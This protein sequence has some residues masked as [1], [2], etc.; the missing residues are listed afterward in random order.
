LEIL[1]GTLPWLELMILQHTVIKGL[2]DALQ[3]DPKLIEDVILGCNRYGEDRNA[4]RMA[5]LLFISSW[6]GN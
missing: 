1:Y 6:R 2:M 4:A 5:G 3:S